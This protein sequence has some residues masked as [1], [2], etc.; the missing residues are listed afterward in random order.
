MELLSISEA[1]NELRINPSRVRSLV[2]SG[3]LPGVKIGGRWLLDRRDIANWARSPRPAGRPFEAANAWG[4]L[5]LASGLD[6]PWLDPQA[7]W[8]IRQA[9]RANGLADLRPRLLRR[10]ESHRFFAH[11]GELGRLRRRDGAVRSGVSAAGAYELDLAPGREIDVYVRA[12]ELDDIQREHALEPAPHGEGNVVL[13]V[14]P[15]SAW[16]LA[17]LEVAPRA[18][19][20]VDL[21]EDPDSRSARIGSAELKRIDRSVRKRL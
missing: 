18:A 12:G 19:V 21:S 14:V 9:L 16:H 15:D 5:F 11:P 6:V 7:H 8:R 4:V 13:R 1:A 20:A 10:S 17:G 2:A 3:K